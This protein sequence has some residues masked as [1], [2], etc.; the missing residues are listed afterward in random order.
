MELLS[1]KEEEAEEEKKLSVGNKKKLV[2]SN[3]M[4]YVSDGLHFKVSE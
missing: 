1:Q 4:V 2:D 3:P